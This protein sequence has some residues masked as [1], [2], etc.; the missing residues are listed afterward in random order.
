LEKAKQHLKELGAPEPEMPPFDESEFEPM[1][2]SRSIPMM[3][4]MREA[5]RQR[6]RGTSPTVR[7]GS[8]LPR[9]PIRG[10]IKRSHV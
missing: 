8:V 7:E 6:L 1:P 5:N 9:D 2:K 4:F 3:S 10:M